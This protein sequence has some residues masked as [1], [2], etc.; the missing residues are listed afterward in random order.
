MSRNNPDPT[1]KNWFELNATAG[2]D[3]ERTITWNIVPWPLK[4]TK[5]GDIKRG[6]PHLRQ[7]LGLLPRLRIVVLVGKKAEAACCNITEWKDRITILK[8]PHPSGKN[9][10]RKPD[11]RDEILRGLRRVNRL[12]KKA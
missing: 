3:R 8:V 11:R 2:I 10:N 1:A 9:I 6:L 12:L 7:L 4:E 5:T